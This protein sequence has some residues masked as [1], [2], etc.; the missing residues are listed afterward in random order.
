MTE[1]WKDVF[2]YE[3]L[4]EVSNIGRVRSVTRYNNK[5]KKCYQSKIKSVEISNNGYL[6]VKLSKDGKRRSACVHRLVAE[7]FIENKNK[8]P[9]VDHIDGNKFNNCV[10][11]LRWVTAKQNI[12]NPNTLI[13][14]IGKNNHFFG[15]KHTEETKKL[16]RVKRPSISG[17][18]NPSARRIINLTTKEVFKTIKEA[19]ERYG[20]SRSAVGNAIR[21]KTK[22]A[23]CYWDYYQN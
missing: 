11:N 8:L 1:V 13:K 22:S 7:A 17:D 16:M 14:H 20:L 21:R 18:K 9:Q 10:E 19:N 3:G 5:S 12:Q 23:G 2:D 6:R 15:K 4:Y